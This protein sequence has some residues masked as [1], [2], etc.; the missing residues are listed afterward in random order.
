MNEKVNKMYAEQ[1]I[2]TLNNPLIKKKE[3][4]LRQIM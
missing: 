4:Q 1:K 2:R 3:D